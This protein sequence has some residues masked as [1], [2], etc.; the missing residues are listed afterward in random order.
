MNKFTFYYSL[1]FSA[2]IFLFILLFGT[3]FHEE[4]HKA[5]WNNYGINSS[6]KYNLDPYNDWIGQTTVTSNNSNDCD[7]GCEQTHAQIEVI[8]NFIDYI[9][10]TIFIILISVLCV[11]Y[12][13]GKK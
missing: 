6:I 4:A 12:V 2:F 7:S 3:M 13:V 8:G 11:L 10:F 9:L 1:F 5:V